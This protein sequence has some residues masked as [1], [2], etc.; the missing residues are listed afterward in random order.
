MTVAVKTMSGA[1][2]P[3]STTPQVTLQ[4]RRALARSK[5]IARVP[6][7]ELGPALFNRQ[8]APTSGRHCFNLAKR[9]LTIE[10]FATYRYTAGYCHEPDPANP[11][12]VADHANQMAERDNLLPRLGAKNLKGVFAKTHLVTLLQLYKHGRMPE[13]QAWV[14]AHRTAEEKEE[15]ED[16]LN[17][18]IFMHVFPWEAVQHHGDDMKALMAS[19]NFDHGHVLTD[20]ELRCVHGM[21]EAILTLEPPA[22]GT[23]Y[24]VVMNHVQRMSGQRWQ[25]KD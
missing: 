13:L 25:E 9:I 17:Y 8:G 24:D 23:H 11:Q 16:V 5:G 22:T 2:A 1:A 14:A 18:G 6:L 21:R 19:D 7:D 12:A 20:S 3:D 4:G 10:G 15:L